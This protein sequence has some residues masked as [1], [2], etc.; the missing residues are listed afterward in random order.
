MAAETARR[1]ALHWIVRGLGAG[2]ALVYAIP[3][4]LYLRGRGR[5]Q[6]AAATVDVGALDSLPDG[7]PQHVTVAVPGNDAW[8]QGG[9]RA[10]VFLVRR[11]DRVDAFDSTCPHTGCAVKWEA[12]ASQ[13]R[14]PCHKSAFSSSGERLAGPAPRGLDPEE[15]QVQAGRVLVRYRRFRP[16][17]PDRVES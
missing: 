5:A 7:V 11:G 2:L 13:F 17:R 10:S 8:N 12:E 14:C 9:T 6:D 1:R 16:G 15:C 4:A 3:G